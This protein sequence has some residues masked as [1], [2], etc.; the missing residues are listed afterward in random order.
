MEL[1]LNYVDQILLY[2]TLGLSLNLLLGYAGQVSVAHAAFGAVGGYTMGYMATNYGWNFLAGTLLG[3]FFAFIVGSI[4]ALPALKLS[5]E[6]LI[7]LTLAVSSVIIG[8][9]TTFPELGGTYGLIGLPDADLFGWSLDNPRD[10][11]IPSLIGMLLVYAFC[12][13]LGESAFGRVLKGVREDGLATQA[14]GKNVFAY[15][16]GVF[17]I[18]SALAGFAGA[19]LAAWFQL[20]TPGVFGFA[21]SLTVFAIVIFG[22]MANLTGTVLGATV[23]VLLDPL[24]R[25]GPWDMSASDAALVQ[26]I[27]YGLAL[28]ILMRVRP[29]GALPEGFSIWRRITKGKPKEIRIEMLDDWE[30]SSAV[31]VHQPGAGLS[32]EDESARERLRERVWQEA[33][34]VLE[35]SGVSKRFGGIVAADDLAIQLRKGTITALVGP[36]GAGKTTVFNLLTGFI[37]PDSGSVLLNG[38]ELVGENPD[39][40]A[41]MG[42]VR[43]FQD[44]RLMHRLTCL[45]NVMLAVQNQAGENLSKLLFGGFA[46]RRSEV[47][48]RQKAMDWLGFVGMAEFANIPAGSLSYGQSKLLSLSRVLATEADVLLLDEPASGID[49]KWVDTVLDLIETVREQGRTVCIVEHNLH[50]VSRLADHTYFMELGRITAQGTIDELANSPRLAEAY[51]GTA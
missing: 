20:A 42:L 46:A 9:F 41:R 23:V 49:T 22:G 3:M 51:F 44:V 32:D 34:V 35:T 28:V 33:P 13:R 7:L 5:V 21:F 39:K 6:Y 17:G 19:L 50:V 14:L 36:N 26:L 25:R 47:E 2:A 16:V 30:P 40:V 10:W 29:Q 38:V 11:V 8:V 48:T 1:W 45:Q 37:R 15:K 43:S 31:A 24:L 4:V 27:V 12:H 18:T